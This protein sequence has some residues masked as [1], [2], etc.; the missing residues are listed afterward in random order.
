MS[1][2][3]VEEQESEEVLLSEGLQFRIGKACFEIIA[4]DPGENRI[5]CQG[6]ARFKMTQNRHQRRTREAALYK[7][8]R[9]R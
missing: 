4:V 5:V 2:D 9:G 3:E 1:H 7:D 8:M 6:I